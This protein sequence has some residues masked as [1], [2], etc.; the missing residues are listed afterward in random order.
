MKG[1]EGAKLE[2][3]LIDKMLKHDEMVQVNLPV[4]MPEI[5]GNHELTFGVYNPKGLHV[6]NTFSVTVKV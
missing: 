4:T 6:G 3:V 2:P 1:P 5:E